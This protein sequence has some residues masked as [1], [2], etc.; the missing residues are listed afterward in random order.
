MVLYYD[1]FLDHV[2]SDWYFIMFIMTHFR[3]G[4]AQLVLLC[5]V[6]AQ[7]AGFRVRVRVN[8]RGLGLGLGLGLE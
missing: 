5:R 8:V 3:L 2:P 7:G 6:R 1:L 4:R